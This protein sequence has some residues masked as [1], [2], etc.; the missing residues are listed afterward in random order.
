MR[1]RMLAIKT[2]AVGGMIVALS[3][4]ALGADMLTNASG[5]ESVNTTDM[6]VA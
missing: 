1:G 2:L 3:G 5:S 4:A 6:S